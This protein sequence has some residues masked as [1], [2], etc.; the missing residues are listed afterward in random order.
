MLRI[1]LAEHS[2][3]FRPNSSLLGEGVEGRLV[4][5][6]VQ[7]GPATERLLLTSYPSEVS[8]RVALVSCERGVS[9]DD[10]GALI[11]EAYLHLA[12]AR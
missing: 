1:V 2:D 3:A 12:E 11:D 8:A 9:G 10:L 6:R 4:D 5:V 7:G